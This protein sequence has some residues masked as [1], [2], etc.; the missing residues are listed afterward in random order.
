ML[1]FTQQFENIGENIALDYSTVQHLEFWKM[2]NIA[3]NA[4][5]NVVAPS[6]RQLSKKT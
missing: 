3:C 6:L 4:H 1:F 5:Y 2:E